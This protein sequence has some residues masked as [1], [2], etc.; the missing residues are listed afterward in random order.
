MGAQIDWYSGNGQFPDIGSGGNQQIFDDGADLSALFGD[1]RDHLGAVRGRE[2]GSRFLQQISETHNGSNGG[3][4]FV[5]DRG[6]ELALGIDEMF[7]GGYPPPGGL[8]SNQIDGR[9]YAS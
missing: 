4:Q 7:E 1:H 2:L 8:H 5:T 3:P 6:D 9:H